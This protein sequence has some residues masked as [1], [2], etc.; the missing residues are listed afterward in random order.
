M[1]TKTRL[2]YM[3]DTYRFEERATVLEIKH[4]EEKKVIIILDQTIFHPQGGGQPADTGIIQ[5]DEAEFEVMD[6]R[7]KDGIVLHHGT[8]KKGQ[9]QP[10]DEVLLRIDEKKRLLHAKLHSAGHLIDVAIQEIGLNLTPTKGYH[11]PQ[12]AYVEYKNKIPPEERER[13]RN[14]LEQ[15]SNELISRGFDVKVEMVE[16]D[17]LEEA[18]GFLPDYIPPGQLTRVVTVAGTLGI[19]CGGTHVNNIKEL[20]TLKINKIKVRSGNT[21]IYYSLS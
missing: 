1:E 2:L 4:D 20:G 19:P 18:C 11:F 12:G 6:V 8:F 17:K 13:I 15:K 21:R 16:Y 9:F 5:N 7:M 10:R 14:L 3:N